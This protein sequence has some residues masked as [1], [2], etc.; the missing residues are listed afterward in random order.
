MRGYVK[1]ITQKID[2]FSREQLS[3]LLEDM[4]GEI[5]NYDSIMESLS[6]GIVI[7]DKDYKLIQNN[8]IAERRL[9]FT[10]H[11]DETVPGSVYLWEIIEDSDIADFIKN[12][13][14]KGTTNSAEDFS[15]VSENG[16]VR[17]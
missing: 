4:A 17:F 5:E 16:S 10:Q 15:V 3:S 11:L 7:V 9:N 14:Q 1:K 2:K 13:A 12:C 8:R 6:A